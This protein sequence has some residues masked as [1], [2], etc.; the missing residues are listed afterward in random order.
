[1][2]PSEHIE[3]DGM[4]NKDE[5]VVVVEGRGCLT[6]DFASGD[7]ETPTVFFIISALT[8]EEEADHIPADRLELMYCENGEECCV[9]K[10]C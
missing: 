10:A 9:F 7:E 3:D 2:I 6:G 4:H 5:G 1:M 8:G